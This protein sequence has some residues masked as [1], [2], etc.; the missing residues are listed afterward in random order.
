MNNRTLFIIMLTTL[1][2][3]APREAALHSWPTASPRTVL[4]ATPVRKHA[5]QLLV[6][7]GN[8]PDDHPHSRH[9]H[10]WHGHVLG[11]VASCILLLLCCA[12]AERYKHC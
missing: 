2:H 11:V 7:E 6:Q 5:F 8:L 9:L 4:A 12:A 1:H 3:Q 10:P